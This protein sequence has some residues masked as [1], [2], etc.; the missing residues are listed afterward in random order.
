V[1][2]ST[3]RTF[4]EAG[5]P[6]SVEEDHTGDGLAERRTE[7]TYDDAT[8]RSTERVDDGGDGN[9]ESEQVTT[10]D[11]DG[12]VL[13][14]TAT[15]FGFDGQ[16]D[17][18]ETRHTLRP[19]SHPDRRVTTWSDGSGS[20]TVY[21]YDATDRLETTVTE[22]AGPMGGDAEAPPMR[23]TTTFDC[24]GNEIASTTDVGRDGTVDDEGR[25]TYDDA[26]WPR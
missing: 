8:G 21:T 7:W 20:M 26:C 12:R 19:D 24:A 13:S 16:P 6:T 3:R 5:R 17:T 10:H 22:S 11:A 23:H 15:Y 4:D 18:V 14:E 9:W 2:R 25:F 1:D